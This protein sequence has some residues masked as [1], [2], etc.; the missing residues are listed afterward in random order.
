[1]SG[2][3]ISDD[4]F[5]FWKGHF[6]GL[7]PGA[8]YTA[9]FTVEIASSAGTGCGGIGGAPGESVFVKAGASLVEPLAL[10][11]SHGQYRMNIDKG[12]QSVGGTNAI[13]L[14]NIATDAACRSVSD[15]RLKQLASGSNGVTV[16]AGSDGG[17]WLL[18]GTDSGFEGAT[19]LYVTRFQAAFEQ[20]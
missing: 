20:Q 8:S 15:W 18:V 12:N 9:R 19:A 4:L 14:G 7:A 1:M 13:V 11:N 17:V 3:N 10:L 2:A 16:Q 5:M 6:V